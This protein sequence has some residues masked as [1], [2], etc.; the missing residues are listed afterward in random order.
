MN[1]FTRMIPVCEHTNQRRK[2]TM[3]MRIYKCVI[4]RL[5]VVAPELK[6]RIHF[7]STLYQ[8]M[9]PSVT[10]HAEEPITH[11]VL[12]PHTSPG[13]TVT[14]STPYASVASVT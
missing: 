11:C 6:I 1:M 14:T 10:H 2:T 7:S 13:N 9:T 4:T 3:V 8:D 5:T 12:I